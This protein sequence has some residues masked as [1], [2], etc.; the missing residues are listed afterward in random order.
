MKNTKRITWLLLLFMICNVMIALPG[1]YAAGAA[2]DSSVKAGKPNVIERVLQF[3]Y[4]LILGPIFNNDKKDDRSA[5]L[6]SKTRPGTSSSLK[7]KTIV[8]DPGH[9]GSNPG[10]VDNNVEEADVNL[11]VAAMLRNKLA[12]SGANVVMTRTS[13]RSVAANGSSLGKELQA[14][15]DITNKNKADIFVSL[16]SNSNPDKKIAGAMTFY[17]KGR[18]SQLASAIQKELIAETDAVD[19]GISAGTFYVLRNNAVPSVL[20]EMGFVTNAAEAAKLKTPSYQ[21]RLAEGVYQG[22]IRY[23]KNA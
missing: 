5:T 2:S 22:I 4:N 10:A 19:K 7:G 8:V 3:F 6:P 17:P 18:S 1:A 20:V 11:A 14:R 15:L 16:H 12:A 13:D 23:F 9:G 21:Q